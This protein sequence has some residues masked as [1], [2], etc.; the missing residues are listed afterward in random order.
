MQYYVLVPFIFAVLTR[1]RLSFAMA[2]CNLALVA[3]FVYQC[4]SPKEVA[5][6]HLL[7]RVWQFMSGTL[8][9]L[10][11]E[12]IAHRQSSAT[13]QK[14]CEEFGALLDDEE[15]DGCPLRNY[16]HISKRNSLSETLSV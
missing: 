8:A 2:A 11:S 13:E 16:K 12:Y 6:G 14:E 7:S 3:S 9:Y 1:I 15:S 5:F 4:R 10:L